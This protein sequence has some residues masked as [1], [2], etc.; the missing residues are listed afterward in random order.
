MKRTIGIILIIAGIIL[1]TMA[2][3]RHD[4]D[5]TI[6]DLGRVEIKNE[7]KAPS[8]NTMMYYILAGVCIIGGGVMLGGK[9]G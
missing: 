6:I 9:K 2:F 1:A 8:E 5:K 3:M 4:K 7:N